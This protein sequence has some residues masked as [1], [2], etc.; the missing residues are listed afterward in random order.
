MVKTEIWNSEYSIGV[1][2]IDDQHKML[3]MKLDDLLNAM[4]MRNNNV[5]IIRSLDNFER[6]V[7][8]CF[9]DEEQI[10][11]DIKY[12]GYRLQRQK[13][14][15]FRYKLQELRVQLENK[16]VDSRLII[17]TETELTTWWIEHI[18][19]LDNELGKHLV[20]ISTI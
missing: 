1:E 12:Y 16:I 8:R 18:T 13:H 3:F 19:N 7:N 15:E 14:D 10:Q 4:R 17:K 11:R 20:T 9:D 6:F 2:K 5:E